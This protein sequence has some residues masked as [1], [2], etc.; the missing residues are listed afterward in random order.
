[1]E[2][3]EQEVFARP[4]GAG[5]GESKQKAQPWKFIFIIYI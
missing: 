2:G 1:M 4:P 5:G 3:N